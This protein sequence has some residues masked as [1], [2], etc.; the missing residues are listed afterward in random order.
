MNT[1][2]WE[3]TKQIL[4]EALRLAPSQRAA[5]LDLACGADGE[6][7]AEVESLIASHEEAGSQFL[8]AA[9]PEVLN[10]AASSPSIKLPA[11][12][13]EHM[14]G[15]Y[16]LVEEIGS[17][18]MGQVWLA[19]Q[20]A[21]VRRRVALKLIRGGMFD[22]SALQR[23]Q[24]ERQSLAMMD[25]PSIAKVF[26]AGATADG[27]PYFVMEYV[28]GTPITDYCDQKRLRIRER[29]ELFINVCEGVQHA[30]QKAIIHRDLKPA[31]ILVAEV[32]G[33]PLPRIIDF[34]LAKG[35]RPEVLGDAQFTMAGSF[36][37][38][39]GYISPEQADSTAQDVD[40]RTDVYSLGAVLYVLLTGFLPFETVQR[41]K[42]PL[43]EALRQ[44]REENPPRPSTKAG[45]HGE[46]TK[47]TAEARGTEP[48]QLVNLLSGDLDW[49][50]LKALERD[51]GRRYATPTDLAADIRRYLKNEPV[52]AHP[53]SAWYRGRK[54][55]RRYWV[56]VTAAALV[57][58]S[59]SAG[60]YVANRQ[61]LIAERRFG[62]LRQLSH[63]VL[64]DLDPELA[65]LPGTIN[66]RSKLVSTSTRYLAGLGADA[67]HDKQ[68]AVEVAQAYVQ[69]ARI[70]GVG[71]WNNLGQYAE[72]E[73]SLRNADAILDPLL[74]A[75]PRN[76]EALWLSANAAHDR[77]T[78]ANHA[79]W[80]EQVIA[81]GS[82]AQER[83]DQVVSLGN[84]TWKEINGATYIYGDLAEHHINLHRFEDAAHY[85]R[86]GIEISR[87]TPTVVGPRA[88][89]FA[90]LA[91][92]LMYLGDFRG[93]L[94]AIQQ[95]RDLAEN[96]KY[97]NERYDRVLLSL[98][99]TKEGLIL[100]E[101]GGINLNRP[102]EAEKSF[103]QAFDFL[104]GL[105]KQEPKDYY[106]RAA[107]AEPGSYL[108]NVLRH[109]DPTQAL[110]V[111]DLALSRVREVPTSVATRR[112]EAILLA[113]SSYAARWIHR[114]KDAGN[115]I[116][117]AFR[118]LSETKDYPA[119]SVKPGSEADTT[120]RALAD[121]FA[122][123]GQPNKAIEL[124]QELRRKIMA[125]NPSP[126]NDLLNAAHVSQ[127]DASLAALLRRVRRTD[128]AVTLEGN[129]LELWRHWDSKLPG[130]PFV[131][132]QLAVNAVL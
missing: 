70:Q 84:L 130:H 112:Q 89:D 57:I 24:S 100:G 32:D 59:L 117:A 7:R 4:E 31:N 36:L 16:R 82:K 55:L 25:H 116:D 76:R 78:V 6:L 110:E 91:G 81:G 39:P 13:L 109:R 122:E 115:R 49:I 102:A 105:A 11:S 42:Q 3:Q 129:R 30:H 96:G 73:K 21:P 51:R 107:L 75:D 103:R 74:A 23:F 53:A 46:S 61:R 52:Q 40:T 128:E 98:V 94:E 68:L 41:T 9:A 132:R 34:G 97:T 126:Q 22:T 47:T 93:A 45:G 79:G 38:T 72:A 121:H 80:P 111:Y 119:E 29:L 85:A 106:V 104:E 15:H 86:L 65:A 95:A 77:A 35:A 118:L 18:G 60:L 58:G 92:A 123:T 56:P 17:G 67:R 28:P 5:Y 37:G 33:K 10:F 8:A 50:T 44:L 27:Q 66:A 20:T 108:G 2:R 90:Q 62:Q 124:Y 131:Q 71:A 125:S 127:L 99:Y 69:I 14:I 54:F 1:E 88:Q 83:F 12:P 26:D 87:T 113:S 63:D 114:E 120:V 64:F 101:D 43:H 48:K 19:E